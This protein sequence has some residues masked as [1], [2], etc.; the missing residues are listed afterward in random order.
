MALFLLIVMLL[1]FLYIFFVMIFVCYSGKGEAEDRARVG[2]CI[3]RERE[4]VPHDERDVG[5]NTCS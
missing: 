3:G 1:F 5:R 4:K 2:Y